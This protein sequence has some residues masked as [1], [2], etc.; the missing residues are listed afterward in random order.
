VWYDDNK[1][2][3]GRFNNLAKYRIG[4]DKKY[5]DT[6]SLKD[7]NGVEKSPEYIVGMA[8]GYETPNNHVYVWYE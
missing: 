2:S 5:F 4:D 7:E 3:V 6:Y 8:L 1:L